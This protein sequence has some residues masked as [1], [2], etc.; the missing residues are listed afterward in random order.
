MRVAGI[1]S[2]LRTLTTKKG[3]PMAFATLEDLDGKS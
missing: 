1:I 2:H 3:D